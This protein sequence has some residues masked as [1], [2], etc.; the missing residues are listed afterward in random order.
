M[1]QMNKSLQSL[2]HTFTILSIIHEFSVPIMFFK[3]GFI[4]P[5]IKTTS[6]TDI[7]NIDVNNTSKWNNYLTSQTASESLWEHFEGIF[8][9]L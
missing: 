8:M 3:I 1:V 7:W 5:Q 2:K 4:S 9:V 6:H